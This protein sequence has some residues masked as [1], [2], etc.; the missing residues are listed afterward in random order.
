MY[1]NMAFMQEE[2]GPS[3]TLPPCHDCK[4]TWSTSTLLPIA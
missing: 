3:P 4:I 1:D 2:A